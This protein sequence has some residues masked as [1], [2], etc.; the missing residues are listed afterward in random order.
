M[1][2]NAGVEPASMVVVAHEGGVLDHVGGVVCS[3]ADLPSD[4]DLLQGHHHGPDSPLSAVPFGKQVPKLQTQQHSLAV[5]PG[6]VSTLNRCPNCRHSSS[7]SILC[8]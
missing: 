7:T 4:P 2:S 6:S 5:Q 1:G 8:T 3:G